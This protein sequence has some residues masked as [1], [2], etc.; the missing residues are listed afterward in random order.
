MNS[1]YLVTG[2]NGH[3]G[4]TISKLLRS[5]AK[6]VRGLVLPHDNAAR[7]EALG[8]DVYKGDVTLIDSLLNF[9]SLEDGKY[10]YD[11]MILIHTAG[12]VSISNKKNPLIEKVNV[13]GT[14]NLI[15]L[16]KHF[17][18]KLFIYVSSVHA[19]TEPNHHLYISEV[20]DF[21]PDSVVG[22]Y[23]K[24][25]AK[26]SQ[27]MA[28]EMKNGFK[29]II[30]HPS[31][32]IGPD[33]EGYG[34]MTMM[35]E[36]YMNGMLTSRVNGAYD[37]VDVRDVALG[38]VQA[39]DNGTIGTSYIL[40][41]HRITLNDLFEMLRQLSGRKHRIHVLPQWFAKLSAPLAEI[42]YKLRKLPPIYSKYS[43]Y[44]LSSN[45]YFDHSK[46]TQ[47]IHYQVRP[48]E[49]TIRDTVFWLDDVNR[50]RRHKIKAFIQ[51]MRLLKKKSGH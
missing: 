32:I 46:A 31:G 1:L 15:T 40:S 8:V 37:F 47:E 14:R 28:S 2:A 10:T 27:L 20:L 38:I 51:S 29:A 18:I 50:I 43:L 21:N 25:K 3:L 16:A 11:D 24:S 36:D 4:F 44:T 23:A 41:G 34:H 6:H 45:S 35:I 13:M 33:D 5:Q 26:A 48:I 22:A 19:I 49:E 9:F 39:I 30:V 17:K 42:F 7:L 12:I